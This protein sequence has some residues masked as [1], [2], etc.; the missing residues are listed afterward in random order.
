MSSVEESKKFIRERS[1]YID[2]LKALAIFFVVL[3]HAPLC[4]PGIKQFIY[5]FHMPV[6]FSVYGMTYSSLKHKEAGFLTIPFIQKKIWRLIL[7][8]FIWAFGYTIVNAVLYGS[9]NP[10]HILYIFYGSQNSL[11]MAHSLSSIWFLPV[12]FLS[13]VFIEFIMERINHISENGVV[14]KLIVVFLIFLLSFLSYE[15]PYLSNGYPWGINIV[16]MA[17]ACILLGFVLEN[18]SLFRKSNHIVVCLVATMSTCLT[19]LFCKFNLQYITLHNVDMASGTFGNYSLYILNVITG[20]LMMMS[21]SHMISHL[22]HSKIL[23][24]IG[25][26]TL[27]IFLIHKPLIRWLCNISIQYGID[28]W[29]F[30]ILYSLIV[31]LICSLLA[32][33]INIICPEII[34]RRRSNKT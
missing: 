22:I 15:L 20:T 11:K 12:M 18:V 8:A 10:K 1:E 25:M 13:V 29:T 34:G 17:T 7:P 32:Y 23:S 24:F 16:P 33:W 31:L 19:Y 2:V 4:H 9:I 3:G 6:F 26:N 27:A 14:Y 30:S 5:S 21:I 28:N